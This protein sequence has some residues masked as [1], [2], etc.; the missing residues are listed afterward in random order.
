MTRKKKKKEKEKEKHG[1]D[2]HATKKDASA[3]GAV[4]VGLLIGL[5]MPKLLI[6]LEMPKP[7][8]RRSFRVRRRRRIAL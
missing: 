6:G 5:E 7:S 2:A 3:I 4:L 8:F 1:R